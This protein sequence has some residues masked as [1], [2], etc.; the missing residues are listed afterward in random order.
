[1]R[2]IVQYKM[3][4]YGKNIFVCDK[5][6]KLSNVINVFVLQFYV[7]PNRRDMYDVNIND[8]IFYF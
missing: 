7:M 3:Q 1:M 4:N 8:S 5:L 2:F 6:F